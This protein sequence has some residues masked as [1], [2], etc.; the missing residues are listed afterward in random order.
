MWERE[1]PSVSGTETGN[2]SLKCAMRCQRI[3][4]CFM[5]LIYSRIGGITETPGIWLLV[6]WGVSNL[7][8]HIRNTEPAHLQADVI[9]RKSTYLPTELT[10]KTSLRWRDTETGRNCR[11]ILL[12]FIQRFSIHCKDYWRICRQMGTA[13][14]GSLVIFLFVVFQVSLVVEMAATHVP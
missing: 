3:D 13:W 12:N 10:T 1:K 9:R 5:L 14:L 4:Y 7:Y 6:S 8:D 2:C 11:R